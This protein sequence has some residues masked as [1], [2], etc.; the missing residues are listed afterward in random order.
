MK[1]GK[2]YDCSEVKRKIGSDEN[3]S[4]AAG[5]AIYIDVPIAYSPVVSAIVCFPCSC[6]H[7]HT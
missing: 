3:A 4:E 5:D 2:F 7:E 6:I 1:E